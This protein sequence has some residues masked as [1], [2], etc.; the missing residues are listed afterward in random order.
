MA[1]RN[2]TYIGEAQ[3]A[4]MQPDGDDQDKPSMQEA[5][6]NSLRMQ[7]INQN[8]DQETEE[9]DPPLQT[10][11][12]RV[13]IDDRINDITMQAAI[14]LPIVYDSQGDTLIYIDAPSRQPEQDELDYERYIKRY[15]AP[16]LM[17]KNTLTK[18]SPGLAQLFGPTQQ[19]RFF[20]RRK[21]ANKLPSNVK[22]VVDLTPP[23]EGEGTHRLYFKS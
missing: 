13:N 9:L 11:Q 18:Y 17:Q 14:E 15:Q 22:Y 1:S 2:L 7:G 12:N 8:A 4:A 16:I 10:C 21:L 20:R 3:S 23:S 19:Y 6:E 5:I